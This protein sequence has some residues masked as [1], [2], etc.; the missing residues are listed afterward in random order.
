VLTGDR[1]WPY[2]ELNSFSSCHPYPISLK[3]HF[4]SFFHQRLGVSIGLLPLLEIMPVCEH[5]FAALQLIRIFADV[6]FRFRRM[7]RSEWQIA[8]GTFEEWL[9]KA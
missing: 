6:I 8:S 7:W 9:W 2:S 5:A 1:H 3:T 4:N